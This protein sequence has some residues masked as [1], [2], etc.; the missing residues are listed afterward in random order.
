MANRLSPTK[1]RYGKEECSRSRNRRCGRECMQQKMEAQLHCG[2]LFTVTGHRCCQRAR[3]DA[4]AG[5]VQR[6]R[7]GQSVTRT[8]G[9]GGT[10]QVL[11]RQNAEKPLHTW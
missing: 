11:W 1:R 10:V 4:A 6:E 9:A 2:I 7:G 3:T 5:T 8:R